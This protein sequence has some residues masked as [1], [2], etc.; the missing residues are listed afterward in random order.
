YFVWNGERLK[1]KFLLCFCL[2]LTLATLIASKSK[3]YG[4]HSAEDILLYSEPIIRDAKK[5]AVIE[6]SKT[7]PPTSVPSDRMLTS[8]EVIDHFTDDNGAE[9]QLIEPDISELKEPFY[10]ATVLLKSKRSYGI[11][12]T[13]Y[14]Y[15]FKHGQHETC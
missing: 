12:S 4:K 1:M 6:Y 14:F 10:A 13:L 7:Y 11:N 2:L 3:K 5:S 8:I 9:P 15:G